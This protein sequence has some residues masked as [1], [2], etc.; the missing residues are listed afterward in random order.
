MMTFSVHENVLSEPALF[1]CARDQRPATNFFCVKPTC[2]DL[3]VGGRPPDPITITKLFQAK[4]VAFLAFRVAH[5]RSSIAALSSG[6]L[7]LMGADFLALTVAARSVAAY[8][9]QPRKTVRELTRS[10]CEAVR[11][12][13][14]H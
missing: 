7:Q 9:V 14:L 8:R 13:R 4:A 1:F 11:P 3:F 6:T 10:F 12:G 2:F 5:G